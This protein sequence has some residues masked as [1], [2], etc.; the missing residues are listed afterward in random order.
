MKIISDDTKADPEATMPLVWTALESM[1]GEYQA[2]PLDFFNEH[3]VQAVLYGHLRQ[4]FQKNNIRLDAAKCETKRTEEFK[5]R[6]YNPV[7][8]EYS[9]NTQWSFGDEVRP[10][11]GRFDLAVLSA[12]QREDRTVWYQPV[13]VAIEIKLWSPVDGGGPR[14]D[15]IKLRNYHAA[16]QSNACRFTGISLLF[17]HPGASHFLDMKEYEHLRKRDSPRFFEDGVALQIITPETWEE[18]CIDG[19]EWAGE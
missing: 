19:S 15:V 16:A 8:S 1:A 2:Y 6:K 7:K 5:G 11:R 14:Q 12:A 9:F 18:V 17:V 4:R 10:G 3:D 13:R